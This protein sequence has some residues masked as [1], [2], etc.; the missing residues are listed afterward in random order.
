MGTH[1]T[2]EIPLEIERRLKA[3][4]DCIVR[5]RFTD[6]YSNEE[7]VA[8][9]VLELPQDDDEDLPSIVSQVQGTTR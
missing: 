3:T 5:V 1:Y 7:F 4:Q 8:E 2:L 6:G 9:T